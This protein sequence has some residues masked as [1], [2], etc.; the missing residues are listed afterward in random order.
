M[1]YLL[2][3]ALVLFFA[4]LVTNQDSR[5]GRVKSATVTVVFF[6]S[7]GK[8]QPDCRVH[9]FKAFTE[10]D[11]REYGARFDGMIGKGIPFGR[12]YRVILSCTNQRLI[13][14][15]WVSVRRADQFLVLSQ[16]EHQGDYETGEIPR[17]T[18]SVSSES[19]HKLLDSGWVKIVGLYSNGQELDRID[20]QSRS[21][22][23]Y[24]VTPGRLLVI[25]IAGDKLACTQQ[26]DV[27]GPEARLDLSLS[28][29]GCEA[30]GQNAVSVVSEQ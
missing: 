20:P 5:T 3:Y 11:K 18:V 14:P 1:K 19:N 2:C 21:A 29:H 9:G 23:F 27:L 7:F 17:L 24:D 25:V 4:G 8:A 13:G 22:R 26:I 10:T 15:F 16:W 6:D 28:E 30:R 12:T